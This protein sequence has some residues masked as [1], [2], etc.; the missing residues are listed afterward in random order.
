MIRVNLAKSVP[1]TPTSG[2]ESLEG[3]EADIK[4][5]QRQGLIRLAIILTLPILLWAYESQNIPAL[6]ARLNGKSTVL[7][8][9][10]AKNEQAKGAVEEITRFKADQ[11]RLQKQIDTLEGLQRERLL[12]VKILDNLQKDIP[13]KVWLERIE[14]KDFNLFINGLAVTGQ[15][16]TTFYESL[17]RSVFLE[18]VQ[19]V[20]EAEQMLDKAIIRKFDINCKIDRS[21]PVATEVA[22]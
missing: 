13:E 11:A 22:R 8:Q 6:R 18:E 12:E 1:M 15:D 5:I 14:F 7:Q 2:V 20:K 3:I 17:S 16:L 4:D 10:Q 19:L 9:L 21:V